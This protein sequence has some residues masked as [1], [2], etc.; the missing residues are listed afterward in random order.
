MRLLT[1]PLLRRRV[2]HLHRRSPIDL[3]PLRSPD[4]FLISHA[5]RDHLDLPSLRRL[6]RR[7]TAIVPRG[8]ARPVERLGFERVV[9]VDEGESVS[10]GSVEVRATHAEHDERAP[11][12]PSARRGSRLFD[13]RL[14]PHLLRGRHVA[15][16][17]DGRP[18]P[19]SRPGADPD[20]GLGPDARQRRAPRPRGRRGGCPPAPPPG[21]RSD[22]LG[23]VPPAAPRRAPRSRV[24][25][26]SRPRTSSA[27]WRRPRPRSRCASCSRA[28]GSSSRTS[29]RPRARR[30]PCP[31][32]PSSAPGRRSAPSP[33]AAPRSARRAPR[34]APRR[35]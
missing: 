11:H 24:P 27:R 13:Q 35:A 9:E 29:P 4:A 19:G 6:D 20:L 5:H 15:L 34:A 21:R 30:R 14:A 32:G 18:R 26:A 22:P 25:E 16:P 3:E 8:L 23:H 7:S 17:G 1:D 31:G 12:R 2:L 33:R 28:S 10:I